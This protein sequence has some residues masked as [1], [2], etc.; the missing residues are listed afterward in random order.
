[1]KRDGRC[2]NGHPREAGSIAVLGDPVNRTNSATGSA[3]SGEVRRNGGGRRLVG[4]KRAA[5]GERM[6]PA[7]PLVVAIAF[8]LIADIESPRSG[9]ISITARN[10]GALAQSLRGP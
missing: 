7:L 4:R 10:L 3:E 1:M 6:L 5:L 8:L 2:G 9:T